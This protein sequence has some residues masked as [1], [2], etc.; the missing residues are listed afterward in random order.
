MIAGHWELSP[1]PVVPEH[2]L[3]MREGTE[4]A[5]SLSSQSFPCGKAGQERWWEY[6]V[7]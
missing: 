4:H 2:L 5:S 1:R 7:R 6:G 3:E